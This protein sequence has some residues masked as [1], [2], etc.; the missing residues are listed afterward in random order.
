LCQAHCTPCHQHHEVLL[1]FLVGRSLLF[2]S[3]LQELARAAAALGSRQAE[4]GAEVHRLN[5]I[6]LYRTRACVSLAWHCSCFR[7]TT[8][9]RCWSRL[10]ARL[11]LF[12]LP[13]LP[14]LLPLLVALHLLFLLPVVTLSLLR[15]SWHMITVGGVVPAC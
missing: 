9:T 5:E 7:S 15:G 2:L 13:R 8:T 4:H 12:S 10:T 1:M 6:G 3:P 14:E 11:R